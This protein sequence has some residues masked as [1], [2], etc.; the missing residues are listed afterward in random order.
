MTQKPQQPSNPS[1]WL[2][3]HDL[4]PEMDLGAFISLMKDHFGLFC[5][6]DPKRPYFVRLQSKPYNDFVEGSK[7]LGVMS[8]NRG[9][10]ISP[11]NIR[12]VIAK[13]EIT[14][15]QFRMEYNSFYPVHPDPVDS[16][17]TKPN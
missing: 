15:D 12:R 5:T 17:E 7:S 8:H 16:S 13:F 3:P 6:L 4:I 11:L 9:T 14:E 10:K 1:R 2:G